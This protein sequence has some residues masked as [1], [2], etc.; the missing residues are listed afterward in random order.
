MLKIFVEQVYTN[1][2]LGYKINSLIRK[3]ILL[4]CIKYITNHCIYEFIMCKFCPKNRS[5]FNIIILH[6]KNHVHFIFFLFL[7]GN[8][9]GCFIL[10]IIRWLFNGI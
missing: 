8:H 3:Y 1:F 5:F 6:L 7:K 9:T 10:I 4:T 2:Y